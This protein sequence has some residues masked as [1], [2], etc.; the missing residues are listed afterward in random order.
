LLNPYTF[1]NTL[2][3]QSLG[4]NGPNNLERALRNTHT[5]LVLLD[6][7]QFG[8]PSGLF[9]GLALVPFVLRRPDL[10][11]LFVLGVALASIGAWFFYDNPFIMYGPR[12]WYEVAPLLVL[13]TARGLVIAGQRIGGVA[14]T[15]AHAAPAVRP[16]ARLALPGAAG[17]V[18]VGL[19]GASLWW[20]W[21]PPDNP[22]PVEN[23]VPTN[24]R[25]LQGFNM[26][27][28]RLV[29]AVQQ[30]DLHEAVVLVAD[31]GG[32]WCYGSVFWLNDPLLEGDVV[33]AHDG[34]GLRPALLAAYPDRTFYLADWKDRSLRPLTSA[35]LTAS[36]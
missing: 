5:Q 34:P 22:R 25:S 4:F 24:V 33:Y 14:D 30:A 13:L 7:L 2:S 8:W 26:V 27:D 35:E 28:P 1:S 19:L 10:R 17:L 3:T 21:A 15:W 20:W 12:F 6:L 32:W 16:F 18:V 29:E 31:C 23:G 36:S 11:D 9:F